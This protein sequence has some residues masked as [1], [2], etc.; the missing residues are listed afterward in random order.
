MFSDYS[1]IVKNKTKF[2]FASVIGT[3]KDKY[4]DF[5]KGNMANV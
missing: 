1:F 2:N 5:A 3:F 4:G